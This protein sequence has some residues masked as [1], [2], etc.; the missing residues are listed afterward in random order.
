[1]CGQERGS[2]NLNGTRRRG[3]LWIWKTAPA[4]VAKKTPHFASLVPATSQTRITRRERQT[5]FKKQEWMRRDMDGL[6]D[7]V[8]RD[9]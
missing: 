1:M 4:P 9:L 3:K 5:V 6:T 8:L 2:R 7:A